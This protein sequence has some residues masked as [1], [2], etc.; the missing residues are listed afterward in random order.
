MI[1]TLNEELGSCEHY[2]DYEGFCTR[3]CSCSGMSFGGCTQAVHDAAREEAKKAGL[4][5]YTIASGACG[6]RYIV[7]LDDMGGL[8]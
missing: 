6:D 3:N 4:D 1:A 7:E 5:R 8:I 2:K